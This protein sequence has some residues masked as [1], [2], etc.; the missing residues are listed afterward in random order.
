MITKANIQDISELEI[1]INSAYRGETSKKGWTTEANILEGI[2]IDQQELTEII[3]DSKSSLF[4]Y[5]ENNQILGCVLLV[6]KENK[7]YLGLL[8][9]NPELQNSGIG[10]KILQFATDYAI[11]KSLPKIVM[12]VISDRTELIDWY[13]RHGYSDS[14][15]REPF[16]ANHIDDII[17]GGDLEFV[18]LE[19]TI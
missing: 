2:R 7:L 13:N 15:E 18:V 10:K 4:K 5:H 8:C 1:L 9:V 16:P 14:G 11:E 12:T 6:E 17:S 3:Q 19:K